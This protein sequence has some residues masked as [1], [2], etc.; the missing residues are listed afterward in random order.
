[1]HLKALG[2]ADMLLTM[3]NIPVAR[4]P[5][6]TCYEIRGKFTFKK[7]L[8]LHKSFA[9][10]LYNYS[11]FLGLIL[12]FEHLLNQKTLHFLLLQQDIYGD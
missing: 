1:M 10:P 6:K 8:C 2:N 5:V 7:K 9:E 12:V 4:M 11:E 3:E